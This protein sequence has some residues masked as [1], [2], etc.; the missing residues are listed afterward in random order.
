MT[1]S[2]HFL[3]VW[4]GCEMAVPNMTDHLTGWVL[5]EQGRWFESEITML[6][7]LL[8]PGATFVDVGANLGVYSMIAAHFVG[9]QGRVVAFE[10]TPEARELLEIAKQ[11]NG[12]AGLVV[13]PEAL[14]DHLGEADLFFDSQTELASLSKSTSGTSKSI[15]VA[16][17]TLDAV[18]AEMDLSATSMVKLDAEGAEE[19]I[20]R[21]AKDFLRASDPVL[22]HE[23]KVGTNVDL[24]VANLL[25]DMGFAPYRH[26]PGLDV[27]VPFVLTGFVD[28]YQLNLFAVSSSRATKLARR[29]VLAEKLGEVPTLPLDFGAKRLAGLPYVRHLTSRWDPSASLDK[30]LWTLLGL[31]AYA[32]DE[33]HAA[34]D[35]W[36]ALEK[37]L[38]LALDRVNERATVPRLLTATRLATETGMRGL[39]VRTVRDA[40]PILR[41]G[42]T[43]LL[44]EP[45][46]MP[47]G[48]LDLLRP[49]GPVDGLVLSAALTAHER[50]RA[51]SSF[52]TGP[53]A[54]GD[55]RFT[56]LLGYAE[57]EMSRR[58]ELVN[59]RAARMSR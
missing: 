44:D 31:H 15:R 20:L 45:F 6:P 4:P 18:H 35:R 23:I 19:S 49:A 5:Y 28:P 39:A 55:L 16:L 53:E 7:K 56:A 1:S 47:D 30:R 24:R 17:T 42:G 8:E 57:G 3:R 54:L 40:L 21:G 33:Q 32:H 50:L 58:L 51:F 9:P 46:L 2:P 11:R 36:A 43:N 52:F 38:T 59:Q 41:S 13:R 37:A 14:S 48:T 10:P 22:L 29:G 12:F 25:S 34:S 27:L 26:L